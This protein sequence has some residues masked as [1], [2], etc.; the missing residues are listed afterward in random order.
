MNIPKKFIASGFLVIATVFSPPIHAA[1]TT[2]VGWGQS[3]S[4]RL[5]IP[6]DLTNAT[7]LAAGTYH[8][9]ALR[10]DSS[11][12]LWGGRDPGLTNVISGPIEVVAV[13]SGFEHNLVLRVDGSLV[14]WG[15]N[16]YGQT[17]IP[18]EAANLKAISAGGLHNLG[19][20]PEGTV[21]AW[22]RNDSEQTH[23]PAALSNVVAIAAG[24]YHSLALRADGSVVAWGLND[25]GQATIPQTVSN[26]VSLAAGSWHN[27]ALRSDGVVLAWG[28]GGN[29]QTNLPADLTNVVEVFAI[30][31]H[32]FALRA[33][34]SAVGWG[35]NNNGQATIPVGVSNVIALAGGASHSL[36]LVA[37][38]LSA[39]VIV[40]QPTSAPT[41]RGTSL[42]LNVGAV[43]AQPLRFQWL[44]EGDPIPLA[45]NSWLMLANLQPA[46]AGNYSVLVSNVSGF[47]QSSNVVVTLADSAP[48]V[49]EPPQ[50]VTTFLNGNATFRVKAYGSEP[51]QYQWRFSGSPI[52]GATN[53]SL[54]LFN[55]DAADVGD[56]TVVIGNAVGV[57]TSSV[58]RLAVPHVALWDSVY[59][60]GQETVPGDLTNVLAVTAAHTL[61]FADR[62]SL[63][64][65]DDGSIRSW[66]RYT[67]VFTGHTNLA[68][69]DALAYHALAIQTN[70]QIVTWA[71]GTTSA[72]NFPPSAS[73]IVAVA[74]GY[75]HSLALRNDGTVLA[76]GENRD[77]QLNVP[78]NLGPAI[79]VAAGF[80]TSAAL[81]ADGSVRAWG[82]G[83]ATN[84]TAAPS[85]SVDIKTTGDY[86][87][88]LRRNGLVGGWGIGSA[89]FPPAG[90]FD[91]IEIG[92]GYVHGAA[93]RRNGAVVT[94]GQLPS[95]LP[96][97]PAQPAPAGLP[98]VNAL[99][100][101]GYHT[102][103][104]LGR[105]DPVITQHPIDATIISG[106]T[107][108]FRSTAV[109][110][111]PLNLQWQKDGTNLPGAMWPTLAITNLMPANVGSYQLIASNG[112]G[113]VTSRVATLTVIPL[114]LSLHPTNRTVYGG[115]STTFTC[116]ALGANLNYQWKF[117]E[118]PIGGA[119]N[120]SLTLS[121]LTTNQAGR[122]SVLVSNA[123]GWGESSNALL[124]VVPIVISTPASAFTTFSGKSAARSVAA[125]KNGPFTYQ[126]FKGD[127]ELT[128]E[129]NSSWYW[130]NLVAS[131]SGL[132]GARVSNPYGSAIS[133]F[134]TL[135]VI[136]QPP[137]MTTQ[138]VNKRIWLLADADFWAEGDGS[139]PLGYRWRL[140]NSYVTNWFENPL[141]P[142]LNLDNVPLARTGDYFCDVTNSF[143][144]TSSVPARLTVMPVCIWPKGAFAATPTSDH[145]DWKDVA[146]G[147][148]HF[149]ALR[150]NRTL[151]AYGNN[152]Y[153][154][155]SIPISATN[156]IAIAS[157][158]NH[159]LALRGDG[160]VLGWGDN[161]YGQRTIPAGLSNVIAIACGSEFSCAL[162]SNGTI[163]AWGRNTAGETTQAAALS[164]VTAI[165]CGDYHG[166]ALLQGGSVRAWGEN[167]YG[168]TNVPVTLS[169]ATAVAAGWRHSIVLQPDGTTLAWG[170]SPGTNV[171]VSATNIVKLGA[172]S[173]RN[174]AVQA[175]GRL[176]NW[177]G[178]SASIPSLTNVAAFSM[179][180]NQSGLAIVSIAQPPQIITHP[181]SQTVLSSQALTLNVGATGPPPLAYQ[182]LK[183]GTNLPQMTNATLTLSNLT[184]AHSGYY[185]AQ[186]TNPFGTALSGE[187]NVRVIV[188]QKISGLVRH[189]DGS[190]TA[191]STDADG[192]L[193]AEADLPFFSVW[194]SSNL[195]NWVALPNALTLSNGV[196]WI[197]D[198]TASNH[199]QRFYQI[200]ERLLWRLPVPQVITGPVRQASGQMT[201]WA[202]DSNGTRLTPTDAAKFELHASTN[203]VNWSKLTNVIAV[204]NGL[205]RLVDPAAG[206]FS[207]RFYRI[208]EKP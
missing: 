63:A 126:W 12:A 26:V 65:M 152:S 125:L 20:R 143:G 162:R 17:N 184:R 103:A 75:D 16:D 31:R 1:G 158:A 114:Q 134:F 183:A 142:S 121:L 170:S 81:R 150:T 172:R 76:W 104:V 118:T 163:A 102:L 187:A 8:G 127:V 2:V 69:V 83:T 175:D 90:L 36:A 38:D 51:I 54:Q 159:S 39:P 15:Q 10:A 107:A 87:L 48:Y 144:A 67:N 50:S 74:A 53:A 190:A 169:N 44:L 203:L 137:F 192:G 60:A 29:G 22:G 131:Q 21:V 204:T 108:V 208:I 132:Y 40:R 111:M 168:Q 157:G 123:F 147:A 201:F 58:A 77:G 186:V 14:A 33:D 161:A 113:S 57:I 140:G 66:G 191:T 32:C 139:L 167:T 202:G 3:S 176:I 185:S 42:L 177:G 151:L 149:I 124:A 95:P 171:S 153:G 200:S 110:G 98:A 96:I 155:L 117:D 106:G 47:V 49:F 59:G 30:S 52:T 25:D 189:P 6:A 138:P 136:D 105:R 4:G 88:A 70:G 91:V 84:V 156:I 179:G 129:T 99:A 72:T 182:W 180:P 141:S 128:G 73:N 116:S 80:Y 86:G 188:P 173:S 45:T 166:V 178:G 27:L 100:A 11:V 206:T 71:S 5:S 97:Q 122:Y 62:Y 85:D 205:L 19:L 64:R 18:V 35:F 199:P 181:V 115:D 198:P 46:Q 92:S 89:Q 164:N 37:E 148:A 55:A 28:Y 43:A 197:S 93:L 133:N 13:D 23:V 82:W 109:G 146:A 56:Y 194:A 94:W 9:I 207:R 101:S 195:I 34:G 193:M 68:G 165:A 154:Q 120:N 196:F 61:L 135:T 79:A 41:F 160:V 174:L 78:T 145:Y 7:A 119:T 24:G 130:L 112:F